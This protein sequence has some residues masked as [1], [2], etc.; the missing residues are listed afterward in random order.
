MRKVSGPRLLKRARCANMRS[1]LLVQR[2]SQRSTATIS[3]SC[4]NS[5]TH[6]DP[7]ETPRITVPKNRDSIAA[8]ISACKMK[9]MGIEMTCESIDDQDAGAEI[10]DKDDL[11]DQNCL[12]GGFSFLFRRL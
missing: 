8:E 4:N 1:C 9:Y 7:S 11:N 2:T 12:C 3:K 5:V 10:C 6:G